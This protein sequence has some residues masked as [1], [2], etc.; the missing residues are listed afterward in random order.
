MSSL[1]HPLPP[2][3]ARGPQRPRVA[4]AHLDIC[5]GNHTQYISRRRARL[6]IRSCH[7]HGLVS[8]L[9][10]EARGDFGRWLVVAVTE[11]VAREQT[12]WPRVTSRSSYKM[13]C[14][15][16]EQMTATLASSSAPPT[17]AFSPS[18]L[19]S[20]LLP[21]RPRPRPHPDYLPTAITQNNY[22]WPTTT[23]RHRCPAGERPRC[24]SLSC[25]QRGN[26]N[27]FVQFQFGAPPRPAFQPQPTCECPSLSFH[28][29]TLQQSQQGED[30]TFTTHML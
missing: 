23:I 1:I 22:G 16:T 29:D 21:S 30:T 11:I 17:Q 2:R 12:K 24:V 6:Q 4:F 25:L 15:I 13:R 8:T 14:Q 7:G 19:H 5:P 9:I 27:N 10:A 20:H 28:R 18:L 3:L 26:L